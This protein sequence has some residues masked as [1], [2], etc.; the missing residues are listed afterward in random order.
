MAAACLEGALRANFDTGTVTA[1]LVGTGYRKLAASGTLD[2]ATGA[3]SGSAIA[4]GSII[5]TSSGQFFGAGAS[6]V[7][8]IATFA[9]NSQFDTSYGGQRN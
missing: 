5:G 6:A 9:G 4:N 3:F 7:T 1:G 2:R 8:G